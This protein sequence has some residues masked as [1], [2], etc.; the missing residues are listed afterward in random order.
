MG[1]YVYLTGYLA[2]DPE[3]RAVA[4]G[5]EVTRLSVAA[6]PGVAK[7]K[8]ENYETVFVQV[9]VW[10]PGNTYIQKYAQKGDLVGVQGELALRNYNDRDGN[11]R[12]QTELLRPN[13]IQILS[14]K[15]DR[16]AGASQRGDGGGGYSRSNANAAPANNFADDDLSDE[17]PF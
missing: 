13:N 2:R 5:K 8:E 16:A 1:L 11:P 6:S 7:E 3:S 9:D 12:T 4:G 10:A 14:R 17:I 15:S